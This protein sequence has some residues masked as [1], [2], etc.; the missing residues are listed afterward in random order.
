MDEGE[1]VP[2]GQA[3]TYEDGLLM[4]GE[5][6]LVD[7]VEMSVR[8]EAKIRRGR[9]SLDM[10]VTGTTARW[11]ETLASGG[12]VQPV[13]WL[14]GEP[15]GAEAFIGQGRFFTANEVLERAEVCVLGY[16][17]AEDLFEGDSALGE[18]V[19]VNRRPCEVIGVL[20]EVEMVEASQQARGR[21]NDGIYLPISTAILNLYEEE[22]SVYITAH[23]ADEGQMDEA[24]E[25]IA[26]YLRQRH[27]I[28]ASGDS[29][30]DDFALTTK[31]DI[32][33]AQQEAARAFAL[34]LT[35]LAV[36]SLTVG[37]IGIMNVMLVSVTER[38][39]EIG[40]RLAVGAQRRDIVAQF[41]LEAVML[42]GV[43]AT[44]GI[45]AGVLAIPLAAA[46]NR[47]LALLD[48]RSLPLALGV[49]LLTGV[50]FG[51]YPALRASRLDPIQALRYE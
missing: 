51:I 39:R 20:S 36:V 16:Q 42:S 11:L 27:G 30:E 2:V 32:L 47:G 15:L 19:W 17:T 50:T 25:Q 22:P 40:V 7:R 45:V 29:S 44:A 31:S 49:G 13:G 46:L 8:A 33:G 48:P 6:E 21:P 37:G 41:L 35:A 26:A 14:E 28:E 12:E 24:K 23:V 5:V 18:G 1:T 3:L 4:P 10:Y 9:V 38:T 34:L 43:S